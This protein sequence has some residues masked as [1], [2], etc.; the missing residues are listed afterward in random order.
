MLTAKSRY[1]KGEKISI[2]TARGA[3]GLR[4]A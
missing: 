3:M 1:L 4:D 2:V